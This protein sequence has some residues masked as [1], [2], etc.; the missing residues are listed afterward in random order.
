MIL[1]HGVLTVS[2]FEIIY[3]YLNSKLLNSSKVQF[4]QQK[5]RK[6]A[7]LDFQVKDLSNLNRQE[8]MF[9]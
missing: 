2:N 6:L 7:F 5:A 4:L 9:F 1:N 8:L 3:F